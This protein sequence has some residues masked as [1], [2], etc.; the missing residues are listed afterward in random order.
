MNVCWLKNAYRES[1]LL[2]EKLNGIAID[3]ENFSKEEF[4][5][6][7]LLEK[8]EIV[9]RIADFIP[10]H[11]VVSLDAGQLINNNTSGST[12]KYM[13][14]YWDKSDYRRSMFSLW[15]LRMKSYGIYPWDKR[16]RFYA[17]SFLKEIEGYKRYVNNGLEFSKKNLD[18]NKLRRIYCDMLVYQ[19]V[20]L[21]LQPGIA[22]LLCAVKNKFRLPH[23]KSVKYIEL[24]G[25]LLPVGLKEVIKK[26]FQCRVANQY[27]MNEV[28]SIA[29]ECRNGNLHCMEENVF[30][31]ILND[32]GHNVSN[33]IEGNIYVTTKHNRGMPFVRYGTGDKGKILDKKCACGCGNRLLQLSVGRKNDWIFTKKKN[34]ISPDV[35]VNS[36][37]IINHVADNCI[38]QYQIIQ[39]DYDFF[40]VKLVMANKMDKI[41]EMFIEYMGQEELKE[42]KFEFEFCEVLHLEKTGKRR[43][44][45]S[46]MNDGIE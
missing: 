19:P 38:L 7:P 27:G 6:L 17:V 13:E 28:N 33:G 1:I 43:F 44:F 8:D 45:I 3:W 9:T 32:E 26:T 5:K 18:E 34:M 22:E 15:F 40:R 39:E 29:F 21:I 10:P 11:Y 42:C 37:E 30:V 41:E 31:E 4:L 35:F 16:C 2:S 46:K 23:I 14:V 24:T 12:G 20:W 25:E 36:I